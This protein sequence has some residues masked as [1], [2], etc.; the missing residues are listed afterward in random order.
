M[1]RVKLEIPESFL[2]STQI[3]VRIT[4]INYGGH[5]GNDAVLSILHEA[6]VRFLKHYGFDELDF[7]GASLIMTDVVIEYKNESFYG[8]IL[9][10]SV[11]TGEFSRAGFELY[12]K[13]EAMRNASHILLAR[14]RT[15]MVCFDYQ[16][17]K[18]RTIP[19]EVKMKF[20]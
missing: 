7:A 12:Y 14:A 17:K 1:A 11:T 6:R 13:L 10:A 20:T 16:S 4:D 3:P 18:I 5:L 19:E 9:I 15:H 2:F 8:D